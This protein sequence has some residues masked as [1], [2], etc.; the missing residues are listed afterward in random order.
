MSEQGPY[1]ERQ[2]T[3]AQITQRLLDVMIEHELES[4]TRPHIVVCTYLD[5]SE[6]TYYLGPYPSAIGALEAAFAEAESVR[7]ELP[8]VPVRA[9]IAPLAPTA[10]SASKAADTV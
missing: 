6:S 10:G 4:L 2:V 5:G 9:T 8:D 1:G 7:F 3:V